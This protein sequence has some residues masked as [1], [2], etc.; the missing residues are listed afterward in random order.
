[1][2]KVDSH[3]LIWDHELINLATGQ[4]HVLKDMSADSIASAAG[5]LIHKGS[6]NKQTFHAALYLPDL[7]FVATEYEL[8][9][10][11]AQNITSALSYQVDELMPA[12][13]GKL[14]LAVNHNELK[15]KNIAL[16]LDQLRSERLFAAFKNQNIE[17]TAIIPR[18]ALAFLLKNINAV[19]NQIR[20]FKELDE[21][22]ILY[23]AVEN[24]SLVQWHNI[25]SRDMKDETYLYQWEQ[26]AEP[27]DNMTLIETSAF[28]QQIDRSHLD[29][30]RYTF[31]PESARQNLKQRSRIKKG[32]LAII[33]GAVAAFLAA[34]PFILNSIRDAKW[35]QKYLDYKEKTA[36][37]SKM[38]RTVTQ[39]ED[40]WAL[41]IEYP[42]ADVMAVI[43]KL[44]TIIPKNSWIKGFEIKSGVVEIDGYSPNPTEILELISHQ[45]EFEQAAFNQRT[46]TERGKDN[47]HFGI[48][49]YLNSINMEAYQEKHF[50]VN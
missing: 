43:K 30:L 19:K 2:K 47:E 33:V 25:N 14:I 22:G 31:F 39:F 1:M 28:W 36:E 7:E 49:F 45:A 6:K 21:N 42:R 16:W 34:T 9:E 4:S 41:F 38:R 29:Q 18:V 32:R 46:R 17:L 11:A 5:E 35:E 13:P 8:P 40:N 12:Y 37:V 15:E 27:L 24:Q 26:K 20:Q 44:N 23:A 10:V 50:P 48:T 3:F